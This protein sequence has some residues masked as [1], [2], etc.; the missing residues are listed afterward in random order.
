MILY[1]IKR[2]RIHNL[3]PRGLPRLTLKNKSSLPLMVDMN[4]LQSIQYLRTQCFS[5]VNGERETTTYCFLEKFIK[6]YR[7]EILTD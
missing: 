2:S 4:L 3:P 7:E 5:I 1:L 6:S